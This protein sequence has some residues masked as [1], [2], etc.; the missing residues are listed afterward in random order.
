MKHHH[1]EN[2]VKGWFVGEFS[3]TAHSINVCE[4]AVKKYRAGDFESLHYHEVA[5]EITLVLSGK[6][7]MMGKTWC[8]G[9]IITISPGEATSFESI[10]DSI[11]VVVKT[12]SVPNDKILS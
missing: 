3:P 8:D 12:P 5:T 9:D 4:V 6:V 11:T 1:L 10:T 7:K 2:M